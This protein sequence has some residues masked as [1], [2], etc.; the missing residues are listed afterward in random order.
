MHNVRIPLKHV[1]H[2]CTLHAVLSIPTPSPKS[3]GNS[4]YTFMSPGMEFVT[5]SRSEQHFVPTTQRQIDEYQGK[6]IKICN[7]ISVV[8]HLNSGL[9]T[10]ETAFFKGVTPL[11]NRWD[12]RITYIGIS[13]WIE[14]LKIPGW[15]FVI[16]K[17]DSRTTTCLGP[18]E[19]PEHYGT[20]WVHGTRI[21]I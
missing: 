11:I 1:D 20:E 18:D 6:S 7:G 5:I 9:E 10:C 17:E 12:T 2:T 16:P 8:S 4:L 14:I 15:L 13:L 19:H 3:K 21:S